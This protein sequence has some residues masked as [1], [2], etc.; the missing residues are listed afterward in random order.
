MEGVDPK[1]FEYALGKIDNGFIFEQFASEFLACVLGYMFVSAGGIHD[2]GIDGLE[3]LF[4]RDKFERHIYQMSI[5][6]SPE[7]KIENTLK[8]LQGNNIPFD[9]F[10]YVTNQK[11]SNQDLLVDN[12]FNKF[13]KSIRVYDL[14]WFSNRVNSFP[15]TVNLYYSFVSNYLHEFVKPG[16]SFDIGDLVSD[17]RLFVFLQQQWEVYRKNLTLEQILSDTLILYCLEGTDPDK[18]IIKTAVEIKSDIVRLIRFDAK[19]LYSTIDQRLSVLSKKPRQIKFHAKLKGYCLPYETRLKIQERNLTDAAMYEEFITQAEEILQTHLKKQD[20]KV[21]DCV[22]LIEQAI[23]SLYYQQGLEFSNFILN[24]ESSEAIEKNLHE[25]INSVVEGSSVIVE[26]R[27]K[28]KA[29]LL[30]AIRDIVYK[31][32]ETQR[33]FLRKLSSTYMMLFLLQCDPKLVTYFLAMA[34]KLEVYVCTSIIIPALSEYYLEPANRRHWNLLKGAYAAGVSLI[35]DENIIKELVSHF[36]SIKYK[37]EMEFKDCEEIY[38]DELHM[39]Y[40]D[41]IMIRAYFHARIEGKVS[42]F[43]SFLDSFVNP[44]LSGAEEALVLWLKEEFGITYR[45]SAT[46]AIQIKKEEEQVLLEKLA[47]LKGHQVAKAR[48]DIRIILTIYALR[49]ERNETASAGIFGYKTWWLS[50]DTTTF[51]VVNEVFRDKYKVSCY[52]RPDFLY[53]YIAL[54]PTKE[55]VDTVYQELFPSLIGANISFHLSQ[56]LLQYINK[57]I[58][59]HKR[60]S[61]ARIKSILREL[62][63]KLKYEPSYQTR[64]YVEHYLDEKLKEVETYMMANRNGGRI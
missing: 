11:C 41:E 20:V 27:T 63:E 19:H 33:I 14:G 8:K 13:Q 15:C 2:R 61:P 28:V 46:L 9:L 53:N 58:A 16:R 38:L 47:P 49:E 52:M 12:L 7:A 31:G 35:I 60:R 62:G 10:V 44:D 25:I 34:S 50:K 36:Q 42:N 56:D 17:P 24:G 59:E 40:V 51:R 26:N 22:S 57:K 64:S 18:G 6:K 5:E 21:M 39:L 1:A 32:G 45:P 43:D 29:A 23:R 30:L 37:Y 3:H 55:D 54:A 48:N 4:Y